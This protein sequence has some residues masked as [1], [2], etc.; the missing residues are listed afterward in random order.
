MTEGVTE[1][2]N[3]SPLLDLGLST[4]AYMLVN[5]HIDRLKC[6]GEGD[7]NIAEIL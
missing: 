6:D 5:P 1:K 7:S 4:K 2:A 3:K